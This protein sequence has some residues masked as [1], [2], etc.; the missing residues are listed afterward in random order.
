MNFNVNI[1]S[2]P[3]KKNSIIDKFGIKWHFSKWKDMS[4]DLPKTMSGKAIFIV[5]T[6][7][8]NGIKSGLT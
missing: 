5:I 8:L 4:T 7:N 3:C 1:F 2:F 6:H